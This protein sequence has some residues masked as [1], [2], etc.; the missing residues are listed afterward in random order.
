MHRLGDRSP[1]ELFQSGRVPR[2]REPQE[3]TAVSAPDQRIEH[4][5]E[6]RGDLGG[7]LGG[8]APRGE[9]PGGERIQRPGAPRSPHAPPP[10][11]VVAPHRPHPP[12]P[13]RPPPPQRPP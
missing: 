8:G 4:A 10:S 9:E 5:V 3:R 11:D 12:P 1:P 13:P 7:T 2:E 6:E